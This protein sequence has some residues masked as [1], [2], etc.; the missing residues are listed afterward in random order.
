MLSGLSGMIGVARFAL[1]TDDL[2]NQFLG[3]SGSARQ[4]GR[5]RFLYT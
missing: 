4:H 1:V 5:S 2:L 3:E